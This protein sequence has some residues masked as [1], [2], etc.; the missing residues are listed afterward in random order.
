M[1]RDF[2]GLLAGVGVSFVGIGAGAGAVAGIR[3]L[4]LGLGLGVGCSILLTED[5]VV[6]MLSSCCLD[7]FLDI[8]SESQINCWCFLITIL[9][10]ND[11]QIILMSKCLLLGSHSNAEVSS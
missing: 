2:S 11:V 1:L 8:F 3:F 10:S 9:K 6:S 5:G 4:G 7:I